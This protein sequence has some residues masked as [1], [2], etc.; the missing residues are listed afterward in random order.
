MEELSVEIEFKK[1]EMIRIANETGLLSEDT[2]EVSQEL[3]RLLVVYQ[4]Q[5]KGQIHV[6]VP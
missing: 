3:D 5:L 1:E 2:L 6:S 4:K